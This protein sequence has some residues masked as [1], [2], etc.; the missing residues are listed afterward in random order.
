MTLTVENDSRRYIRELARIL[1]KLY[2]HE[3]YDKYYR[4][5]TVGEIE[6]WFRSLDPDYDPL[7]TSVLR[8]SRGEIVGYADAWVTEDY[9]PGYIRVIIDPSLPEPLYREAY[10]ILLRWAGRTLAY[11]DRSVN[12]ATIYAGREYSRSHMILESIM[13]GSL[14]R[15]ESGI[16]MEY[17]GSLNNPIPPGTIDELVV[18]NPSV[19]M[20]E[21][22]VE[23]VNDAFSIYPDHH[24]WSFER[25]WSYY[26]TQFS[27][28]KGE[29][30]IIILHNKYSGEIG[31]MAEITHYTTAT[32]GK[33]GYVS[34]L[35]VRR[36]YQRR[37][38]GKYLLSRAFAILKRMGVERLVLDSVPEA[39]RMY[40]KL[41]FSPVFKWVKM[42]V[43]LET[44]L[45]V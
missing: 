25:A 14:T 22:L 7:E 35:A 8:T 42:R 13:G 28:L 33:V 38:L 23:V 39:R 24:P 10:V 18:E 11:Y 19:T 32:G 40:E 30:F 2:E 36:N 21:E 12:P 45:S 34:L 9:H 20:V 41:G 1:V 29:F 17:R 15:V 31:G 27:K 43:P 26:S 3:G 37:G 44:V 4:R 6:S 16:L 5:P